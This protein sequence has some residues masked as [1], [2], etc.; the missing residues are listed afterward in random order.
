MHHAE[1]H[2]PNFHRVLTSY[3]ALVLPLKS[4]KTIYQTQLLFQRW[5]EAFGSTRLADLTPE[6]LSRWR[7]CWLHHGLAPSTVTQRLWILQ[8]ILGW[9]TEQGWL[10]ANPMAQV[11][12]PS[13]PGRRPCVL[14]TEGLQ[15]L[16]AACQASR[17]THLYVF[18]S[19]ILATGLRK[20]QLCALRWEG[21]DLVRGVLFVPD[22]RTACPWLPLPEPLLALLRAKESAR[23]PIIPWVFPN[24][25]QQ[26]PMVPYYGWRKAC[27]Q[28]GLPG[29][30]LEDLRYDAPQVRAGIDLRIAA[31]ALVTILLSWSDSSIY[32]L[33][34][35]VDY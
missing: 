25:E 30:R 23:C 14:T 29:L 32:L 2:I 10:P 17:N 22:A 4:S 3:E 24:K 19:L 27:A 35:I 1:L 12:K 15:R 16:L 18:V 28:A 21:L 9:A 5:R 34:N 33:K 31:R 7:D 20:Q 6:C 11:V 8:G 13:S 26:G